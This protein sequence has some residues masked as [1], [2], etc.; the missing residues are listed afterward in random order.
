MRLIKL[1]FVILILSAAGLA[2]TTRMLWEP[3]YGDSVFVR[4]DGNKDNPALL[5]I[6]GA[7]DEAGAVW[8]SLLPEL[9][10]HYYVI[11]PDLPGFGKS[12]GANRLYDPAHYSAVLEWLT[13]ELHANPVYVMGHSLGGGLA[14]QFAGTFPQLVHKLVL[15]DVYGVLHRKVLT[16]W[17][18]EQREETRHFFD[19]RKILEGTLKSVINRFNENEVSENIN[20][21]LQNPLTRKTALGGNPQHIVG[22]ALINSDLGWFLDRISAATLVLW[23]ADDSIAPIQTADVLRHRL[24]SARLAILHDCGHTPMYDQPQLVNQKVISFLNNPVQHEPDPAID[25]PVSGKKIHVNRQR[26]VRLH[27]TFDTIMINGAREIVLDSVIANHIQV[28]HSTVS[29]RNCRVGDGVELRGSTVDIENSTIRGRNR[30]LDCN[31]ATLNLT[32]STVIGDTAMCTIGSR[33]EIAGVILRGNRQALA[34]PAG[35]KRNR[36]SEF[37]ISVSN[38]YSEEHLKR[39]HGELVIEK[40]RAIPRQ[41][42]K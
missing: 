17:F 26:D 40:P 2:G 32:A 38:L 29:L 31:A 6:H 1:V 3:F 13:Q 4:L 11:T 22:L 34:Y 18:S 5:L 25:F 36:P 35:K 21:M 39:R 9:Q 30:G 33:G 16:N 20:S 8:Q 42:A 7:G 19:P 24:Q 37:L 14:I 12:S 28:N 41:T 23:G 15:I 27:G 10:K